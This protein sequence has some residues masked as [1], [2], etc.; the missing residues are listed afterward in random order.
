MK[1]GEGEKERGE[2]APKSRNK[3]STM[4]MVIVVI[5]EHIGSQL[6]R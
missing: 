1:G 2:F 3:T 5:E 6:L 4:N